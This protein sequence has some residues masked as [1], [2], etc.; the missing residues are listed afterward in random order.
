MVLLESSKCGFLS[1]ALS[2]Q[3]PPWASAHWPCCAS[4]VRSSPTLRTSQAMAPLLGMLL[5]RYLRSGHLHSIPAS[6][7]TLLWLQSQPWPTTVTLG[8]YSTQPAHP[9]GRQADNPR[10]MMRHPGSAHCLIVFLLLAKG[11]RMTRFY[12]G[13]APSSNTTEVSE[14]MF[15]IPWKPLTNWPLV[16]PL[17]QHGGRSELQWWLRG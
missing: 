9:K 11:S 17:L 16:F 10:G 12:Q 14:L 13:L 3:H 1:P 6:P 2:A 7:S 8:H 4:V 15:R 5:L